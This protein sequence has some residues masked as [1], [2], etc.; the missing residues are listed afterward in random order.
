[1]P[2]SRYPLGLDA[3][4]RDFCTV[5]CRHDNVVYFC[6]TVADDATEDKIAADIA[7]GQIEH[8]LAV[9]SFN[10]IEGWARDISEDVAYKVL[11]LQLT[12]HSMV[13]DHVVQF[14]ELHLDRRCRDAMRITRPECA[15]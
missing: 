15:S 5:M 10:P 11:I 4:D 6:E 9:F 1:M 2:F 7:E 8:A 14:L 12:E 3:T 13:A